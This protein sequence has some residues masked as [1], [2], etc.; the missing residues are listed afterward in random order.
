MSPMFFSLLR[1]LNL[2]FETQVWSDSQK[3]FLTI[4]QGCQMAHF[5]TKNSNFGIFWKVLGWNFLYVWRAFG[6]FCY[7]WY[8]VWPF[9]IGILLSFG[10]FS[11]FWCIVPKENLA[12]LFYKHIVKYLFVPYKMSCYPG[13]SSSHLK[14]WQQIPDMVLSR[15]F[16]NSK[17]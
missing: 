15:S 17:L 6:I 12:I 7:I 1:R 16:F 3:R 13:N 2:K 14:K 11:P 8:R 5:H 10:A 4:L 9:C